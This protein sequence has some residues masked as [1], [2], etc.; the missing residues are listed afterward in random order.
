MKGLTRAQDAHGQAMLDHLAGKPAYEIVERDD[1]FIAPSG[2]PAAYFAPPGKWP[3]C[4]R[5]AMRLVRG[6]VL[7]VGAGAGRVAL[8]LQERGHEVL[9][10]DISPGAIEVCRRRGVRDARVLPF[11]QVDRRLGVFDSIVLFGNN[12]GLFGSFRRAR[13]LLRRLKAVTPERARIIAQ[14]TDVY[15]TNDPLHRSYHR[16]NRGRERMSGQ[17]RIRVHYRRHVTPWFDYLIVSPKEL[18][19]ILEGTGWR[20]ERKLTCSPANQVY[21]AV[22]EKEDA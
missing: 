14:T 16:L 6:R 5:Q 10:I 18:V 22:I 2:G 12:F 3:A 15:A 20:L 19:K 13:W 1:G 4:E 21:V 7:D 17:L 11:A 9:A 8:H